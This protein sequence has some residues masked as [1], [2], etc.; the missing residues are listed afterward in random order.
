MINYYV[1]SLDIISKFGCKDS[2]LMI[3]SG[4]KAVH[5]MGYTK[6]KLY[7][8]GNMIYIICTRVM[9]YKNK[10]NLS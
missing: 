7:D 10:Y 2:L 8:K 1:L 5:S 6:L 3:T 4:L 9:I